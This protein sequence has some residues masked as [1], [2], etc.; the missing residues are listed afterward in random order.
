LENSVLGRPSDDVTNNPPQ[1]SALSQQEIDPADG[2]LTELLNQELQYHSQGE[3]LPSFNEEMHD[4]APYMIGEHK[5]KQ[6]VKRSDATYDCH[7]FC[8]ANHSGYALA[9]CNDVY[10]RNNWYSAVCGAYG[11]YCECC[12][13]T[14]RSLRSGQPRKC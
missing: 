7:R 1:S 6:R 14:G 10:P 11:K 9:R 12:D 3:D 13:W 2:E 4:E 5:N 8:A